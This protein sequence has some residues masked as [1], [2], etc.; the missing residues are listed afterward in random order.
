MMVSLRLIIFFLLLGACSCAQVGEN[1][2]M[3]LPLIP[4]P[5]SVQIQKG[6][7]HISENTVIVVDGEETRSD[8]EVFNQSL[9]QMFGM[10]L[11]VLQAD[12]PMVNPIML[13]KTNSSY[14]KKDSYQLIVQPNKISIT[15]KDAG[16]FYGLQSLLQLLQRDSSGLAVP[17]V[18]VGDGPKFSWRG[19]HLDVSR[20]FFPKEFIKKYIDLIALYKMNTFHWHLTDDQGWRIEIKKYPK[21]T[22]VGAWR[23]G[24]M[25]GAYHDQQF[26][27]IRYGGFYTQDDIREIVAYAEKRHVT[28][29]P[30]IEMPGHCLAALA[31]YPELACTGGPFEVAKGWGVFDDVYCPKKETFIFL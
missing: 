6:L 1:G 20:H 9:Q 12:A 17:A 10:R 30:E 28:V 15:G 5:E 23:N 11:K 14:F 27:T 29:V 21:L 24:S 18:Q 26:D 4:K 3:R 25:V 13:F 16:V 2:E 8:A 19:M 31:S 7:F 22:E